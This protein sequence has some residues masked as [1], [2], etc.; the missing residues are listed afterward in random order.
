MYRILKTGVSLLSIIGVTIGLATISVE[1]S[2][3]GAAV[4]M[5]GWLNGLGDG[6]LQW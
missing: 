5:L 4:F 6:I 1:A 2:A 3:M